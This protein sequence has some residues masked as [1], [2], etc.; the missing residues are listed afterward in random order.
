MTKDGKIINYVMISPNFPPKNYKL[1]LDLKL[2]L[3]ITLILIH[4]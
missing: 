2:G 3:D 1:T 4:E